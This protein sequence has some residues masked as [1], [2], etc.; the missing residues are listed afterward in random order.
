MQRKIQGLFQTGSR[1]S[2]GATTPEHVKA[3]YERNMVNAVD[4]HEYDIL[5]IYK[6]LN[7]LSEQLAQL[8]NAVETL[9][10]V[11]YMYLPD[12][13]LNDVIDV[14]SLL[15]G[16][17]DQQSNDEEYDLLDMNISTE[18]SDTEE[19]IPKKRGRKKKE[20]TKVNG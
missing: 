2:T 10:E 4:Q 11:V 15:D 14:P 13:V 6:H 20:D 3:K 7:T 9:R 19:V 5:D 8:T 1:V 12:Q 16:T 18:T 17:V